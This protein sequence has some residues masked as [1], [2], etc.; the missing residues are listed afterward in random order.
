MELANTTM[1]TGPHLWQSHHGTF[2]GLSNSEIYATIWQITNSTSST[3]L[4]INPDYYDEVTSELSAMY[5][6]PVNKGKYGHLYRCI[7]LDGDHN[8]PTQ[9]TITCY[10]STFK[11]HVQGCL[12]RAWV[13]NILP[14]IG[15]KLQ[16]Q[17]TDDDE[18]LGIINFSLNYDQDFPSL[19]STP[20]STPPSTL[21]PSQSLKLSPATSQQSQT[22]APVHLC[23]AATQTDNVPKFCSCSSQTDCISSST[24]QSSIPSSSS[25]ASQTDSEHSVQPLHHMSTSTSSTIEHSSVRPPSAVVKRP[26]QHTPS[27]T[28]ISTSNMFSALQV[29]D[30]IPDDDEPPIPLPW[31]PSV[32]SHCRVKPVP[33]RKPKSPSKSMSPFKSPSESM[34]PAKSMSQSKSPVKPPS[35]SP[36][37]RSSSHRN[38]KET[39]LIIGDSIPKHLVGRKMSKRYRVLNRCIPGS[40]LELW[41]KLAP[42]MINEEQPSRVI[43]HLG[44]NNIASSVTNEC[45][46]MY[47]HLVSTILNV[48]PEIH[49]AVSSLTPQTNTGH[50]HWITEFNARLKELCT[51]WELSFIDNANISKSKLA[52]DGLHLNKSGTISLAKNFILFINHKPSNQDFHVSQFPWKMK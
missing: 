36:V 38:A 33:S 51:S 30:T 18:S 39:V 7:V 52:A 44:T 48:S 41:T 17:I 12:H 40:R 9:V 32:N 29:E 26:A 24:L 28:N 34:S 1:A 45:L 25:A 46:L 5:G 20:M 19:A 14:D 23:N 42:I 27:I 2:N 50:M 4:A 15:H 21:P 13:D 31:L 49:I 11:I 10:A 22:T 16:Q 37:T 6:N 35:Q 43:I 47:D 3:T 8:S